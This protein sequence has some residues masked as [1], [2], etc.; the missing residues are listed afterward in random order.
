MSFLGFFFEN[1]K[2]AIKTNSE[3]G[4]RGLRRF[5]FYMYLSIQKIIQNSNS[6]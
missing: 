4:L 5:T 3:E 1:T 6:V 2:K